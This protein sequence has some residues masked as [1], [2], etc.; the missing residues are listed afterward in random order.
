V[1]KGFFATEDIEIYLVAK[2]GYLVVPKGEPPINVGF[3]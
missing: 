3:H 2:V 1:I